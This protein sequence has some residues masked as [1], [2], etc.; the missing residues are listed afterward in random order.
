MGWQQAG[1]VL[2]P[3]EPRL[4]PI[5]QRPGIEGIFSCSPENYAAG[6][7]HGDHINNNQSVP[8]ALATPAHDASIAD[9]APIA[10]I[11]P[12]GDARSDPVTRARGRDADHPGN[13]RLLGGACAELE[14]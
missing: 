7:T 13:L 9:T 12:A 3:K 8:H 1:V 2:P 14:R 5:D 6:A 4:R 11:A 10:D